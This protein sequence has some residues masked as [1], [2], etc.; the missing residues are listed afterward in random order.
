[1]R[2]T[3]Y[4]VIHNKKIAVAY[5]TPDALIMSGLNMP[6]KIST[7]AIYLQGTSLAAYNAGGG[8]K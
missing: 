4:V 6:V 1:V 2:K 3:E 7:A 5:D 8:I